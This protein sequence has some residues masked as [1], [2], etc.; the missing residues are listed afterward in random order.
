MDEK[1]SDDNMNDWSMESFNLAARMFEKTVDKFR[2]ASMGPVRGS[3]PKTVVP[4]EPAVGDREKVIGKDDL[5][6]LQIMLGKAETV[7]DFIKNM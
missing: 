4:V 2:T 6:N 1:L 7:D 3:D 5:T